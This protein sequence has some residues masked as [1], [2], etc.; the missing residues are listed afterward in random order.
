M[1]PTRMSTCATRAVGRGVLLLLA[2]AGLCPEAMAGGGDELALSARARLGVHVYDFE[3]PFDDDLSSFFDTERYVRSKADDDPYYVDLFELDAGLARRDGTPLLLIER[4]SP[5]QLNDRAR[6]EL[7]WEGLG[8]DLGYW[9]LR[10]DE[11]RVYP[12]GTLQECPPADPNQPCPF[13]FGTVF[14]PD[15]S[16]DNPLGFGDQLWTRR[17][18][19]AG[20]LRVRPDGF[21][22]DVPRLTEVE[23]YSRWEKRRGERQDRFLLDLIR[24]PTTDQRARFRAYRREQD[25]EVTTLGAGAVITPW[26]LFTSALDLNFERCREE[27]PVVTLGGLAAL[28]PRIVPG[29]DERAA[30]AFQFVPDTDRVTGSAR[31]SRRIGDATFHGGGFITHLRQVKKSPL[32]DHLRVDD[33]RLT[34]FSAHAAFDMPLS[35]GIRL[36]AF[37][38]YLKRHRSPGTDAFRLDPSVT[39]SVQVDPFLRERRELRTGVALLAR[40]RAGALV[41]IG[42]RGRRVTR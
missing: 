24:E 28:D 29:S 35:H 3:D 19:L 36:S 2:L 27:A 9:R 42:Y 30:R 12:T 37:G 39:P 14:N 38:K 26:N 6:F 21:A 20:K 17:T 40:P 23:L 41:G 8:I 25:Q 31:V 5:N 15:T 22:L 32:Q 18:G 11:L 10:T 16:S 13:A 33:N 1:D 7:D 4:R 34:T